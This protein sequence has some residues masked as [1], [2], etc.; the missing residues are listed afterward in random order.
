MAPFLCAK[1]GVFLP[2]ALAAAESGAQSAKH[3]QNRINPQLRLTRCAGRA[4]GM[5]IANVTAVTGM[6]PPRTRPGG[7]GPGAGRAPQVEAWR[8]A[9][10]RRA[11]A[12]GSF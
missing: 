1:P 12:P 9:G 3:A 7:A 2:H 5:G 11:V 4:V 10:Q 8:F 6:P